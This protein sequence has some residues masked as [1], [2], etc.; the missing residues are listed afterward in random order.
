[1][2]TIAHDPKGTALAAPTNVAFT[3]PDLDVMVVPNIGRWHL[4]R[5][6]AGIRGVPLHYPTLAPSV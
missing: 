4:T 2:R 3:G 5:I 6:P 1:L